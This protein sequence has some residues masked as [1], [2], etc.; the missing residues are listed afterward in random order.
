ML[1]KPNTSIIWEVKSE[2][3]YVIGLITSLRT[4]GGKNKIC[5]MYYCILITTYLFNNFKEEKKVKFIVIELLDNE[6]RK[7]QKCVKRCIVF[8]I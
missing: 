3:Y 6:R 2:I 7:K 5:K 4:K 1:S 8:L